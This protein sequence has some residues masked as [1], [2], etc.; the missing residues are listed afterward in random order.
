MAP[1]YRP[2]YDVVILG[3]GVGALVVGAILAKAGQKVLLLEERSQ[4]GGIA[5][6]EHFQGYPV[7][8]S[9]SLWLGLEKEGYCDQLLSDLG[10]SLTMLKRAGG[11]LKRPSPYLQIVTDQYRVNLE[12]VLSD[13][14]AEYKREW[15]EV[16]AS[17]QQIYKDLSAVEGLLYP[18]YFK[19]PL[20]HPSLPLRE[21]LYLIHQSL[22]RRWHVRY[23]SSFSS[24][25]FLS[26]YRF[27]LS[28][29]SIFEW[30]S[31]LWFGRNLDQTSALEYLLLLALLTREVVRPIG[32]TVRFCEVLSKICLDYR[33]E[34]RYQQEVV[35]V[36]R[37]S[38]KNW[39]ISL[40]RGEKIHAAGL[41][42]HYPWE[43]LRSPGQ[44]YLRL[45][46][47]VDP[48][49]VPTAM[50][51]QLLLHC[52]NDGGSGAFLFVTLSLAEEETAYLEK[53]RL[54]TVTVMGSAKQSL[55]EPDLRYWLNRVIKRLH[56]LM[57]FSEGR[58]Q[59]IGNH[60]HH[61]QDRQNR[62]AKVA[63]Q[64]K[65]LRFVKHPHLEYAYHP[66]HRRLFV[67]P[68]CG[69]A[70]AMWTAEIIAAD[71]VA[72]QLLRT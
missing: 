10:M 37:F 64:L 54:L 67:L 65:R 60:Q 55:T 53:K 46:F 72:R 16:T 25:D 34:I 52:P 15:G 49:A 56:W 43:L 30:L 69:N 33:A 51:E 9:P 28:L 35:S 13:Q 47:L 38:R 6:I 58:I 61:I 42:V 29:M 27:P 11:L 40:A 68:D 2:S 45:Y 57:P 63:P 14:L 50:G 70:M 71:A 32:G 22:R 19:K 39:G 41:I 24:R 20:P 12:V 36:Q 7:I 23:Y 44:Q 66:F 59:Y 1:S 4:L 8:R 21:K 48:K 31:L 5:T 17:L 3:S 18:F 26:K 62:M